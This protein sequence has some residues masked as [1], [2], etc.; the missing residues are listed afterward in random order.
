MPNPLYP[1][2]T[3]SRFEVSTEGKGLPQGI[4]VA[5]HRSVDDF[6]SAFLGCSISRARQGTQCADTRPYLDA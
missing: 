2:A 5:Q 4:G 6:K 3:Y 1:R